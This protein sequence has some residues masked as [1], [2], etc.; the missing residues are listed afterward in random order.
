MQAVMSSRVAKPKVKR[1]YANDCSL[2]SVKDMMHKL[3][4]DFYRSAFLPMGASLTLDDL[5][6]EACMAYLDA[7]AKYEPNREVLFVT[8]CQWAVRNR[9]LA[10]LTKAK[11]YKAR[12]SNLDDFRFEGEDG[13]HG[14]ADCY[15]ST[16]DARYEPMGALQM[17]QEIRTRLD[18]LTGKARLVVLA[19]L[20]SELN[21]NRPSTLPEIVK[22]LGLSKVEISAVQKELTT[23]LGVG[24]LI[25]KK[26]IKKSN[27][28]SDPTALESLPS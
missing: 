12:Y 5:F 1:E 27:K 8:Y 15:A 16:P 9:I 21:T 3:C 13:D 14:S 17:N 19:L 23:K 11:T 26:P 24:R 25:W 18:S 4:L 28:C 2:E 6:Q 10:A 7:K 20:A 22:S